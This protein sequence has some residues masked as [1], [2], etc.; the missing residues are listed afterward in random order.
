MYPRRSL[1]RD[2]VFSGSHVLLVIEAEIL[3]ASL[4][5]L[6]P[7]SFLPLLELLGDLYP[8]AL[9]VMMSKV[10]SHGVLM[11]FGMGFERISERW[12]GSPEGVLEADFEVGI[13]FGGSK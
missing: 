6:I 5:P 8:L 10:R 12:P 2:S 4:L 11:G 1:G 7:L 13:G 3:E 9:N